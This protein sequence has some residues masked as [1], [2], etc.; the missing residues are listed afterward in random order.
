MPQNRHCNIRR[1]AAPLRWSSVS[2]P[3]DV[4]VPFD[5]D[6]VVA[7]DGGEAVADMAAVAAAADADADVDRSVAVTEIEELLARWLLLLLLMLLLLLARVDRLLARAE[8]RLLR[9]S[10]SKDLSGDTFW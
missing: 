3:V 7:T 1:R 5:V 8:M 4:I 9:S 10:R 2:A 6:V